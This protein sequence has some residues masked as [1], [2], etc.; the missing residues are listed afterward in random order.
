[1]TIEQ[2]R[3]LVGSGSQH[4]HAESSLAPP[5]ATFRPG[6]KTCPGCGLK[7]DLICAND[8]CKAPLGFMDEGVVPRAGAHVN[9]PDCPF[10]GSDKVRYVGGRGE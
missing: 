1:L 5:H 6:G 4:D 7:P 2:L 10:C 8:E 3:R 9:I